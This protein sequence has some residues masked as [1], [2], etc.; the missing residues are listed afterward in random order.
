MIS[1]LKFVHRDRYAREGPTA[2]DLTANVRH[3]TS[4]IVY[5]RRVETEPGPARCGGPVTPG[6]K[7]A[8][9]PMKTMPS[10]RLVYAAVRVPVGIQAQH[11][12]SAFAEKGWYTQPNGDG[13][14]VSIPLYCAKVVA[15]QEARS[16][17]ASFSQRHAPL[18]VDELRV[19]EPV[20]DDRRQLYVARTAEGWVGLLPHR[21]RRSREAPPGLRNWVVA[22]ER[23]RN[24][25]LMR[26]RAVETK[27]AREVLRKSALPGQP[28]DPRE[29]VI[30]SSAEPQVTH[31]RPW[32]APWPYL[33]SLWGIVL[34]ILASLAGAVVAWSDMP[35]AARVV[36]GI[37]AAVLSVIFVRWLTGDRLS[38]S[39]R[40]GSIVLGL[41]VTFI[42]GFVLSDFPLGWPFVMSVGSA[43]G[44]LI[45][46]AVG[47]AHLITRHP[48]VRGLFSIPLV[49]LLAA[50]AAAIAQFL[51]AVGANSLG[52]SSESITVP[53]WFRLLVALYVFLWFG[54]FVALIGGIVGWATYFGVSSGTTVTR[55]MMYLM[56]ALL[57]GFVALSLFG[58]SMVQAHSIATGWRSQLQNGQTPSVISDFVYRACV[59]P[60][61]GLTD[62]EGTAVPEHPVALVNGDAG[63]LWIWTMS[64][65]DAVPET[66]QMDASV[67]H[68]HRIPNGQESCPQGPLLSPAG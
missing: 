39:V 44:L 57:A 17:L 32:I 41:L 29:M 9:T 3:T 46:A 55:T 45:V 48:G 38:T 11:A 66:R 49:T 43:A 31:P 47:W 5:E 63:T 50:G 19:L 18:I 58:I 68:V 13:Y 56:G 16:E 23:D 15:L 54:A 28:Y 33:R 22:V 42:L 53:A 34:A 36:G 51:I 30:A 40:I 60:A 4:T 2:S 6:R 7:V 27:R 20:P 1:T 59:E 14:V 37:L 61:P 24:Q 25:N 21:L 8:M 10:N 35:A 62:V 26:R 52:L 67:V 12:Q 64:G 65:E